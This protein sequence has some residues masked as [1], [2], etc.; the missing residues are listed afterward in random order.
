MILILILLPLISFS[1]FNIGIIE[2]S[3]TNL[4]IN[5]ASIYSLRKINSTYTGNAIRVR[6]SN[7]NTE[8]DIGFTSLGDLDTTS[9][10]NFVSSNSA[11][12]T[13]WYSQGDSSSVNFTQA[14]ALN[15]PRIILNGIIDRVNGKVSIFFNGTSQ[16]MT[17]QSS[18]QK[19]AFLHQ[20]GLSSIYFVGTYLTDTS[21]RVIINNNNTA[22]ANSGY[23]IYQEANNIITSSVSRGVGGG[24]FTSVITSQNNFTTTNVISILTNELDNNNPTASNRNKLYYNNG[25]SIA[26]NIL[27]NT[28]S[29]LNA[30]NNLTLGK[31]STSNLF[32]FNGYMN[33]IIL[34]KGD[35]TQFRTKILNNINSYYGIY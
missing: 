20:T 13:T 8:Q 33:E 27:T 24:A 10:K 34:Y 7:D 35:K 17:V 5:A 4:A 30:T 25:N 11:F 14:T 6:R 26:T 22:S 9:L 21:S 2:S 12:I 15:Q 16:F 23:S 32:Y 3:K 28:P 1:Q 19:F 29:S 18:T 31:A